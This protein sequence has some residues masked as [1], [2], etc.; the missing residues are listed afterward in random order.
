[1]T[2]A[3]TAER[4]RLDV[5]APGWRDVLHQPQSSEVTTG[6]ASVALRHGEEEPI[7]IYHSVGDSYE[8]LGKLEGIDWYDGRTLVATNLG[9]ELRLPAELQADYPAAAAHYESI[10][11]E[12]TK[13]I[14]WGGSLADLVNRDPTARR[15]VSV[16]LFGEE[17]N[18]VAPNETRYQAVKRLNNKNEFI[19]DMQEAGLPTPETITLEK[20]VTP[21]QEQP[22]GDFNG[23]WFVKGAVAASGQEVIKCD[24]WSEVLQAASEMTD[25]YQVQNGVDA[26]D[27]L[28][29][30]YYIKD[31]K[32]YHVATTGQ[33]LEGS[34]HAGNR[35]PSEHDPRGVSDKAAQIAATMGAEGL[36]AFDV[37][38]IKPP[39]DGSEYDPYSLIECNPRP[40]GSSYPT[41][42][43]EKL[44]VG[45]RE[46]AAMNIKVAKDLPLSEA[47][48]RLQDAGLVF[49][50]GTKTGAV[51]VNWGT[52]K[53][54]KLGILF[55]GT[56]EQ[57]QQQVDLTKSLLGPTD[58]EINGTTSE[59]RT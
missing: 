8:G 29:V 45:D 54:G 15:V 4:T 38:A 56:S 52:A 26:D 37:A 55:V 24:S 10:G 11:L 18:A 33:I 30:Q 49:D 42:T 46:W 7:A 2:M 41:A 19:R 57:Q 58:K 16:F 31:G 25:A 32:A 39:K 13:N 40:N 50:N 1:M 9:D 5:A 47:I 53:D 48:Q 43:A 35:H 36:I 34:V 21:P 59:P 12:V 20:G 27:F 3:P 17:A 51:V 22:E 6:L 44:G 28:N 23:P 14:V